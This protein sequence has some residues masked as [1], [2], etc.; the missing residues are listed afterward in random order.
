MAQELLNNDL[1][2]AQKKTSLYVEP[3]M[4]AWSGFG[5]SGLCPD[6]PPESQNNP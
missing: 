5:M 2:T 6:M 1:I 4:E 3:S